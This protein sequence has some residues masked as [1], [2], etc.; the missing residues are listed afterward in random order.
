MKH[1]HKNPFID[2]AGMA[3]PVQK[4]TSGRKTLAPSPSDSPPAT[5]R[6]AQS[7]GPFI[8]SAAGATPE[9]HGT[10][11]FSHAAPTNGSSGADTGQ[12]SHQSAMDMEVS[13]VIAGIGCNA[14]TG[15]FM[16]DAWR[17]YRSF[18]EARGTL[19]ARLAGIIPADLTRFVAQ[20]RRTQE[21][22]DGLLMMLTMLG[23]LLV[24]GGHD[25]GVTSA[26]IAAARRIR[27]RNASN[28]KYNHENRLVEPLPDA[29]T[30]AGNQV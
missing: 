22:V 24:H 13:T 7:A 26:L 19:P 5:T 30:D 4:R 1:H 9:A 14:R 18:A 28:G 20:A 12:A 11:A 27:V 6:T 8:T 21:D 16:L 25:Q 15:Q 29:R 3:S 23:G 2:P 17:A 10:P